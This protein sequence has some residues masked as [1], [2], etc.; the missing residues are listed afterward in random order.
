MRSLRKLIQAPAVLLLSL[1][2]VQAH[3]DEF[4]S[5]DTR[6]TQVYPDA[7][8]FTFITTYAN[9]AVSSCDN[10]SRWAISSS[11]P[12]YQVMVAALLT[13]FAAGKNVNLNITVYPAQ[14]AG[15]VNRFIVKE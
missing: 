11:Y 2:S 5:G 7:S 4:W 9:T 8:G 15:F 13:A 3:A 1:V 10:G 14:C 12:N 6:I